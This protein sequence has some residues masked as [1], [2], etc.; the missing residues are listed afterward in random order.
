[1]KKYL[2]NPEDIDKYI[3]YGL[4][5]PRDCK[6]FYIGKS[7]SG[8][9][10]M[11]RHNQPHSLKRRGKLKNERILD[12]IQDGHESPLYIILAKCKSCKDTVRKERAII[13]KYSKTHKLT[14]TAYN[15]SK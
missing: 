4:I 3:V 8:I 14:N 11:L 5:D 12:I 15:R 9:K 7:C 13:R 10:Q 2:Y 6:V 1:M